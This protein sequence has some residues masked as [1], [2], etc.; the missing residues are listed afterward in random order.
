MYRYVD[1]GPAPAAS[2][3]ATSRV[4][5]R[6]RRAGTAPELAVRRVKLHGVVVRDLDTNAQLTAA[7]GSSFV[8]GSTMTRTKLPTGSSRS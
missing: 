4:M 7:S 8:C 2:S 6:T 1:A 5:R 3:E